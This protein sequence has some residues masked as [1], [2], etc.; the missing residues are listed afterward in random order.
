VVKSESPDYQTRIVALCVSLACAAIYLAL[1]PPLFDFDGYGYLLSALG[2]DRLGNIDHLHVLWEPIQ[3]ALLKFAGGA[4]HP[5]AFLFQIVGIVLNCVALFFFCA[6]LGKSS[7][8]RL[9]AVASTLFIAF[10]PRFWYLGFQNEPYPALFLVL[11]LYLLSWSSA[12]EKGPDGLRLAA[13]VVC[14][15][16]G[17]L[18]HQAAVCFVPAGAIALV[19]FGSGTTLKRVARS[20][21]WCAAIAA[22]VLPV[23]LYVW[24]MVDSGTPFLSWTIEDLATQHSL[25]F[26]VPSTAI[27]AVIGALGAIVQ[28]GAI[29]LFLDRHLSPSQI[30]GFYGVIGAA[31]CC[32]ALI[33]AWRSGAYRILLRLIRTNPLFA[34]SLL[35]ILF[36]SAIV[37]AYEP[38]TQNYWLVDILLAFVAIGLVIRDRRWNGVP[39][40]AGV[41]LVLSLINAWLNHVNDLEASLNAPEHLV[42]SIDRYVGKRDIFMILADHDWYGD[43]E[44]ELLFNY[45]RVSSDLRGVAILNDFV[46]PAKGSRSWRDQLHNKIDSTLSSCHRVFVAAN[47]L[48]P[49][50][51]WDLAGTKDPFSPFVNKE[52]VGLNGSELMGQIAEVLEPYRMVNSELRI[53]SDRYFALKSG[54]AM[55]A[56]CPD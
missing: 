32:G 15:A 16:G 9:F 8:S 33:F 28:D 53:G 27:K 46:L 36:W 5:P 22:L 29:R 24:A 25:H 42:V 48:D 55:R 14:L 37:I 4:E 43:V 52:Y 35:S 41:L 21:T 30:L 45:L 56:P 13:G 34:V 1:R 2:P 26:E 50:S 20:V 39:A 40:L 49:R 18:V 3:I 23:Y 6:L 44:Y 7:G 17:I 51:Y 12:N 31:I 38:V 10:S 54:E 47:V 11:V 19:G